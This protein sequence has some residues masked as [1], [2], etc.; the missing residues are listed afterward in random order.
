VIP[1]LKQLKKGM[2]CREEKENI[3]YKLI[4]DVIG[5]KLKETDGPKYFVEYIFPNFM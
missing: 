2:R 4:F 3:V 1:S 5:H